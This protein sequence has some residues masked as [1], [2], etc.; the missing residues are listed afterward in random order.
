MSSNFSFKTGLIF[1]IFKICQ[2]LI[3]WSWIRQ[4]SLLKYFSH[5]RI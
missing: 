3:I 2:A 5:R 1:L 4:L